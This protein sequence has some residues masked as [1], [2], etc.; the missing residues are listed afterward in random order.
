MKAAR[1]SNFDGIARRSRSVM[2]RDSNWNTAVVLAL[3]VYSLGA[4]NVISVTMP[5]RYTS[6]GTY[7]DAGD[8]AKNLGIRHMALPIS[9]VHE[10][11]T[12]LLASAESG[13]WEDVVSLRED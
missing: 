2:P 8:L 4:S 12:S 11:F 6:S 9:G 5:S 13:R 3:A 10:Q 7:D 1:S